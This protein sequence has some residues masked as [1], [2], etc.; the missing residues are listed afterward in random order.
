MLALSLSLSLSLS[1]P[2]FP[3]CLLCGLLN[4]GTK[5]VNL[6]V[7]LGGLHHNK[8]PL[9]VQPFMEVVVVHLF[10]TEIQWQHEAVL[11]VCS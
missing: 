11:S 10:K 4:K 1:F 9:V 8:V 3:V 5:T 2:S 7:L 6:L